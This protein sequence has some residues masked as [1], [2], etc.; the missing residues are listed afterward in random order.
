MIDE[1]FPHLEELTKLA[2]KTLSE[3]VGTI[4]K[5]KE[6]KEELLKMM[7]RA[8]RDKKL[9]QELSLQSYKHPNGFYKIILHRG[10]KGSLRLHFWNNPDDKSDLHDHFWDLQ[11]V[12]LFGE[13]ESSVYSESEEGESFLHYNLV[14]NEGPNFTLIKIGPKNIQLQER[15]ILKQNDL[16]KLSCEKTHWFYA[17]T[18]KAATLLVQSL[19]KYRPNNV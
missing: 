15:N 18:P 8:L 12:I 19:P 4:L 11:S 1:K 17:K 13:F 3:E 6:T 10:S 5:L 14:K 9:L 2:N 16:H 7:K